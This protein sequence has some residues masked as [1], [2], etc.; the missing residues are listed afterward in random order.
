[1]SEDAL[2]CERREVLHSS[3]VGLAADDVRT[4]WGTALDK[5]AGGP[6]WAWRGWHRWAVHRRVAAGKREQSLIVVL[7]LADAWWRHSD[8]PTALVQ[9]VGDDSVRNDG[10]PTCDNKRPLALAEQRVLDEIRRLRHFSPWSAP[11]APRGSPAGLRRR[12]EG[13]DP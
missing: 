9:F 4:R 5:A 1:M 10:D 11:P 8:V 2:V 3:V 7:G 6:A 13:G 12:G